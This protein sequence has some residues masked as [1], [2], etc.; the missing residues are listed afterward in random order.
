[1]YLS[2]LQLNPHNRQVWRRYLRNPYTV[3]QLIMQGFPDG[4]N[5]EDAS[6]L[7]RLE[8]TDEKIVLLVQSQIEPD[9]GKIADQEY[10]LPT[11]PYDFLPNPAVKPINL[12]FRAGQPLNFRLCA[13]PA[14]KK[15][16]WDA[17]TGQSLNSNRVP[18]LKEE[19]QLAWLHKR[20]KMGGFQVNYVTISQNQNQ[21]IWKQRGEKPIT[22]FSIQFDGQLQVTEP[23]SIMA[24]VKKGIGPSKAFGCGLLSV[25]PGS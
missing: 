8:A 10:L 14:I 15:G 21:K 4:V 17:V 1:M 19:Q 20:A 9:W 6:V 11:D 7:H 23:Q 12:R 2:R 5:R 16:R 18:L 13:N 25:A 24:A 3:H 22:L